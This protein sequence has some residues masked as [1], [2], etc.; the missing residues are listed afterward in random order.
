ME[1]TYYIYNIK[2]GWLGRGHYVSDVANAV[3][4]SREGALS[5]CRRHMEGGKIVSIP[6]AT[7]DIT[8][9]ESDE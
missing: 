4:F 8:A 6:I 3:E 7:S 9:L 5:T 1:Q 2:L